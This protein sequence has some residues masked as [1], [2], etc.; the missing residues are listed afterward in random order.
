MSETLHPKT[1]IVLEGS[2]TIKI[3]ILEK[4]IA[5]RFNPVKVQARRRG[6]REFGM[7]FLYRHGLDMTGSVLNCGSAWDKFDYSRFFPRCTRYRLLDKKETTTKLEFIKADIQDIP[8]PSN[9]EDCIIAFAFFFYLTRSEQE[10]ALKEFSRVLKPDGLLLIDFFGPGSYLARAS[11][12]THHYAIELCMENFQI[13]N[14][15]LYCQDFFK[16]GSA[17][18]VEGKRLFATFIK[19]KPKKPGEYAT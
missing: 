13:L 14:V 12:L 6:Y 19:A 16:R 3:H 10:K 9:S 1:T 5:C 11:E 4:P 17:I 18:P 15:D 7:E 2:P 8:L